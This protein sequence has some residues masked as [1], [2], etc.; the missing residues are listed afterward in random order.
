MG[1]NNSRKDFISR[2][3]DMVKLLSARS[4]ERKT[5]SQTGMIED[6]VET[7]MASC[8]IVIHPKV[9]EAT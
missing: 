8:E 9:K 1:S 2:N 5:T 3:K 4:K 6:I 7:P